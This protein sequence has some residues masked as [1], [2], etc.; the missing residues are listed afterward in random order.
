MKERLGKVYLKYVYEGGGADIETP[1]RVLSIE[2][3]YAFAEVLS[4]TEMNYSDELLEWHSRRERGM[5]LKVPLNR[6]VLEP[7]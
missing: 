7:Q 3:G 5:V 2:G 4:L 1:V 6:L